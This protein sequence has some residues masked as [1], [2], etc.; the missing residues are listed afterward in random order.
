MLNLTALAPLSL[1]LRFGEVTPLLLQ[2]LLY[3]IRGVYSTLYGRPIFE[4]DCRVWVHG[5]VYP[6]VYEL[7]RDFKYNPIDDARFALLEGTEN[8]LT[9]DEK[10]VIDLVSLRK[11]AAGL[12]RMRRPL[13]II[14]LYLRLLPEIG[15]WS[16]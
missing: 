12:V 13:I 5:L 11:A 4:E 14:W 8:A 16:I 7:F 6:E 15:Q 1:A 10:R 3:F 9:D 2:K